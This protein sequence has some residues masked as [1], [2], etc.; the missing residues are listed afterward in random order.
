MNEKENEQE[1]KVFLQ[2]S[3]AC[4]TF[5]FSFSFSFLL[6]GSTKAAAASVLKKA[7]QEE[8]EEIDG[9]QNAAGGL[10]STIICLSR[11]NNILKNKSILALSGF[12]FHFFSKTVFLHFPLFFH[13]GCEHIMR[14]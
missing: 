2:G 13:F 10:L 8:Q 7:Q 6:A 14:K 11:S 3:I 4:L 5:L 1:G 9:G 12:C